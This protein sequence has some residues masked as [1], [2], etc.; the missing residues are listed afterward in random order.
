MR[1]RVGYVA[2]TLLLLCLSC[3][4]GNSHSPNTIVQST[5]SKGPQQPVL[6]NEA[7]ILAHLH[8]PSGFLISFYASSLHTPRFMTIGPG[9]ALLVA[10]PDSN[11]VIAFPP[12]TSPEHA[13]RAIVI[14]NKLDSPSS[15]VMHDGYL[16][17][18]EASSIARMP[19]G[20]D[21]KVGP[22]TRIVTGLPRP[23]GVPFGT[24]TILIGPDNQLY[25][26]S[27][28]DCQACLEQD[29]HRAAVW[30]YDL[31][32]SHG[33]LFAKGLPNA[34]GMAVNPWMGQI[35]ADVNAS[36]RV[37]ASISPE[38]IYGL[39][40]QSDYGWPRCHAGGI[41]DPQ[42]GHSAG[43]CKGIPLPIVSL[44]AS[45]TPLGLAFHPLDA[46]QFPTTY[47]NSLYV[48]L[49]GSEN[50]S[51]PAGFKIVR[52]PIDCGRMVGHVE[53]FVSGWLKSDGTSS[54][55]P[56]GITFAPDG[57]MFISDDKTG[58]IYH[59]WYHA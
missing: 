25:V 23:A 32:G 34:V 17:V 30:Q 55:R 45:S 28:S 59:V 16:Y 27:A 54:G 9:G 58:V 29:P 51:T 47:R 36:D 52:I 14:S 31:D 49:Y 13:G 38:T 6:F 33:L 11:A 56:V 10:E 1:E 39:N 46:T 12:G 2:L 37:N 15:L 41:A 57:S 19:L 48:A 53:D 35:W 43:A 50:G 20:K 42:L 4:C 26:S 5:H 40:Y 22:I 3:A 44:Q 8:V 24:H 18:S 21:L 7:T